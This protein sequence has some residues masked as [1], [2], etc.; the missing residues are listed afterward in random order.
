[1]T[2]I[3]HPVLVDE[4]IAGLEIKPDGIYVDATFGRGGHSL[5][6]LKRLGVNGRLIAMDRDPEA[7]KAAKEEVF[8]DPR[9][10]IIHDSF[11]HLGNALKNLNLENKVSGILMDFGV[12]SPQLEDPDRGFSFLRDGPLDMRMNPERGINAAEWLSKAREKEIA[13]VLYEFGE[14]RFARKI[15]KAI[16]EQ[17][18]KQ[19]L[20]T[21]LQL[22]RLIEK[23]YPKQEPGKHP[24]TR[25][26][27]AIRI[28]VNN[29][30][31]EIKKGLD[32][33]LKVLAVGGRLCVISFHSLEDEIA[34]RFIQ[35]WV[36]GVDEECRISNFLQ[37]QRLR[38]IGKLIRPREQEI[39]KNVRARSARM[40][41]AEKIA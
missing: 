39:E 15:A 9:F 16:V 24:A 3:H 21:T 35:K 5:E 29:E 40:R 13:D 4:V 19:P 20:L 37:Q 11:S 36:S 2:Y 1:M 22:A 18:V 31:E 6:I 30:F 32:A 33:S 27:Q 23:C 26:F 38:K 28:F 10:Q 12:S 8:K 14:E 17:R 7:I 41:V 25:S 34:K